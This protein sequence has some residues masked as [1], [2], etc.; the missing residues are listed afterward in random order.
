[1]DEKEFFKLAQKYEEDRDFFEAVKAAWESGRKLVD[2]AAYPL[3]P[4]P[5]WSGYAQL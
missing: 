3:A 5:A 1:M 4:R 2:S